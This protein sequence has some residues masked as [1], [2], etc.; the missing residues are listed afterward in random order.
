M[1]ERW[2]HSHMDKKNYT[3]A[4]AT[5]DRVARTLEGDCTEHAVLAAAMCRA[6]GVPARTAFG[7]IYIENGKPAMGFHMWTEVWVRGQWMPIDATLGKG[8]VGATHI[9][10]SDHSW[11]DVQTVTPLLPVVRVVGKVAIRLAD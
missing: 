4:F 8:F 2:V 3:E 1:I 9:K 6:V 7:L 5:A 11:H 10:V